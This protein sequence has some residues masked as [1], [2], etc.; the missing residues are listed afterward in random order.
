M[1]MRHDDEMLSHESKEQKRIISAMR[2]SGSLQDDI[3]EME[4]DDPR[5]H[6]DA[7]GGSSQKKG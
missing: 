3:P 5:L 2:S 6:R 4:S 1:S 7:E